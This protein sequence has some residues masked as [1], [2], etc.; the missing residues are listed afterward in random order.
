MIYT[1]VELS[2]L[3]QLAYQDMREGETLWSALLN[4]QGYLEK[5]LG[6]DYKSHISGLIS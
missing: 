6:S 1:D 4:N 5:S 2:I 3:S